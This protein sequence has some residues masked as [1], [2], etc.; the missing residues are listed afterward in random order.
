[1]ARLDH[2]DG[3]VKGAGTAYAQFLQRLDQGRFRV[4]RRRLRE[5]LL[6]LQLAKVEPLVDGERRQLL[7]LVVVAVALPDAIETVEDEHRA[8]GPE[9][10][11]GGADVDA[12]LGEARG[13]HPAVGEAL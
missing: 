4:T 3:W 6:R 9:H 10:V 2:L 12:G 5:V 8:V 1:M 13:R 11:I 7:L